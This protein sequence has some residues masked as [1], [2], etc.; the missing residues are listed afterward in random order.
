MANQQQQKPERKTSTAGP[1]RMGG[2]MNYLEKPQDFKG[3]MKKL[4]AYLRPYLP[5]IL[6]AGTLAIIASVL[7]VLSP[8]L[9]GLITSEVADAFVENRTM[10]QINIIWGISLSIGELALVII[11]IYLLSSVFNYLQSFMLIGMTQNLTYKM[12][13][14]LSS[15]INRLPLAYFDSQ[16]FGDVLGRITNDVETINQTL[17]QSIS[18]IFRSITLLL[19]IFIIMLLLSPILTG[20]VFVT[21]LMSLWVARKFVKLSQGYFRQQAKSYGELNGHIEE[22]YSGHTVV[23][24]FNHQK[25]SYDNFDRINHELYKSSLKS[26]FISGIMFPVQFFIGNLAYIGIAVIGSLLV[27]STNPIIAIKVGIIQA[28]IVYTRQINQP[29]QQIGSIANVLQSTAAASERILMLLEEKEGTTRT[30]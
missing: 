3:T 2:R 14:D 13:K 4:G 8:W 17:T 26:Q 24:I 11:C 29:I 22:T 5:K 25:K 6:F 9:L 28:F 20:L 15:K 12:R 23:K 10:G 27:L 21:T 30:R 7:T 18:E 16:N 19:G 1:M